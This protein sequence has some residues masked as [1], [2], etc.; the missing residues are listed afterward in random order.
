MEAY[1]LANKLRDLYP[2]GFVATVYSEGLEAVFTFPRETTLLEHVRNV[3][4]LTVLE[5]V[6]LSYQI[7][8]YH[9]KKHWK[10]RKI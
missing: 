9:E 8:S 5:E 10:A 7:S 4:P 3:P 2:L 1:P 6:K